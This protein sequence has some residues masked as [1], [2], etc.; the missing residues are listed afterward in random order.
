MRWNNLNKFQLKS[1]IKGTDT[2]CIYLRIFGDHQEGSLSNMRRLMM[3]PRGDS[4]SGD[5][6]CR[7]MREYEIR[8]TDYYA[9]E[10]RKKGFVFIENV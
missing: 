4:G 2:L 10:E 9:G 3:S 1:A 7:I 6:H 8:E 5:H